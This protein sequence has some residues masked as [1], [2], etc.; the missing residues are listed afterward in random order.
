MYVTCISGGDVPVKV[1]IS[2]IVDFFCDFCHNARIV[3]ADGVGT[4]AREPGD[5][6]PYTEF[7]KIILIYFL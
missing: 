2:S 3:A 5:S 7:I 6:T 4:P 1:M